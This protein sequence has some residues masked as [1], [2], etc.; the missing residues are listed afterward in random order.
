MLFKKGNFRLKTTLNE[1]QKTKTNL[2]FLWEKKENTQKEL[3]KTMIANIKKALLPK[4]ETFVKSG[5]KEDQKI[6]V[7][8]LKSDIDDILRPISAHSA[9]E[10]C[11]LT[12][13]ELTVA[14]FVKG[15]LGSKKIA[16]SLNISLRTV[17]T[18]RGNIRKKLNI[19]NKHINLQLHLKS[20]VEL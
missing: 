3:E 13:T 9:Y 8:E 4:I 6:I 19:S 11:G 2:D 12:P 1:L 5:L 20:L 7:E 15:G 10:E 16:E 14:Q 18:H 17:E